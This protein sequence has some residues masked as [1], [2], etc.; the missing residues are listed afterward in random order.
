M[1]HRC[2]TAKEAQALFL[3][4]A[5][6]FDPAREDG[7]DF[8]LFALAQEAYEIFLESIKEE[9][10]ES[11]REF[12]LPGKYQFVDDL[13]TFEHPEK[14]QIIDEIQA[15]AEKNPNFQ[16]KFFDSVCDQFNRYENMTAKQYN[17]LVKIYY[18]FHMHEKEKGE[19]KC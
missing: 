19:K 18:Q 4:L 1:F 11:K 2:K 5:I 8:K 6:K 7:G 13:V 17:A 15:F 16:R 10:P 9:K 3:M 12:L 14:Y